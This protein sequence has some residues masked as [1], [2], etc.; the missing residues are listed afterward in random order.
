MILLSLLSLV[1]CHEQ[2]LKR[3]YEVDSCLKETLRML[4]SDHPKKEMIYKVKEYKSSNYV[5]YLRFDK[6]WWYYRTIHEDKLNDR[7]LDVIQCPDFNNSIF[8]GKG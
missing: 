8:K 2:G 6:Q 5:L 3:S 1:G 7:D 4:A